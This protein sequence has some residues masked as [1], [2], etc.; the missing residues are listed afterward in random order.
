[1]TQTYVSIMMKHLEQMQI[2]V[3]DSGEKHF[4]RNAGIQKEWNLECNRLFFVEDGEGKLILQDGEIDLMPGKM[5]IMLSGIVH[6]VSVEPGKILELKWCH[7]RQSYEDR[8]LFRSLQ[9]PNNFLVPDLEVVSGLFDRVIMLQQ[10]PQLTS[11]LRVKSVMLELLSIYLEQITIHATEDCPTQDLQKIDAVIRY[12]DDHISDNITVEDLAKQAY[13][14]PNYFIAMFKNILGYS[15]IQYVIHRRIETAKS[16]LARPDCNVSKV[17]NQVG[18]QIYHFSRMFKS[19][20]GMT[21][22]RYRRMR[23]A[24]MA[25]DA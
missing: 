21:P 8:E 2:E 14:H 12:I 1:M 17:A 23:V 18:M 24:S 6:R 19:H 13:L 25:E 4:G 10:Y 11:Q 22:S 7:Y 15:P 9:L 16:L 5:V 20:T 3:L